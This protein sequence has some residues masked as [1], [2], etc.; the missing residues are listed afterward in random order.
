MILSWR[1]GAV[2]SSEDKS[3]P[4]VIINEHLSHHRCSPNYSNKRCSLSFVTAKIVNSW[5]SHF[6]VNIDA[7]FCSQTIFY[8]LSSVLFGGRNPS[9]LLRYSWYWWI[10]ISS[11]DMPFLTVVSTFPCDWDVLLSLALGY[12]SRSCSFW[13]ILCCLLVDKQA[14]TRY[15]VHQ[16]THIVWRRSRQPFYRY[17]YLFKQKCF[18]GKKSIWMLLTLS[19][20]HSLFWITVALFGF[21]AL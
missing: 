1:V 19:K 10:I 2:S 4:S 16:R 11:T 6:S 17:L 14:V 12:L 9:E 8:I 20:S 15:L 18:P 13:G 21:S 7:R 3:M 5:D